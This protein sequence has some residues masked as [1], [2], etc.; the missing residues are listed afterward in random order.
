MCS[1]CDCV[2]Y[3]YF[4]LKRLVLPGAKQIVVESERWFAKELF[5]TRTQRDAWRQWTGHTG[6][7]KLCKWTT[8]NC[9]DKQ[10]TLCTMLPPLKKCWLFMTTQNILHNDPKRSEYVEFV[11]SLRHEISKPCNDQRQ[12]WCQWDFFYW[13]GIFVEFKSQTFYLS[14]GKWGFWRK[15]S[16][17]WNYNTTSINTIAGWPWKKYF[18]LNH[19]CLDVL[20]MFFLNEECEFVQNSSEWRKCPSL[21]SV[22]QV[23]EKFEKCCLW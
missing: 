7:R 15:V 10:R 9:L 23:L 20:S 22:E 1:T 19:R 3:M 2:V 14:Q 8:L 16:E 4:V 11:F 21:P 6:R 13:C 17:N 12:H 18:G 5:L